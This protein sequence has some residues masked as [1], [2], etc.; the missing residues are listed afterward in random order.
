MYLSPI[1]FYV[2]PI[3]HHVKV[4]K[5]KHHNITISS[6]LMLDL[7]RRFNIN[8]SRPK[9]IILN[10]EFEENECRIICIYIDKVEK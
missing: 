6:I 7:P 1:H 4:N 3:F 9:D 5:R 2:T 8:Y 10:P